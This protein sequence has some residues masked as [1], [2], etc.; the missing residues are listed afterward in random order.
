MLI[1]FFIPIIHIII[2]IKINIMA[3]LICISLYVREMFCFKQNSSHRRC[4]CF[5]RRRG[6]GF[7]AHDNETI[8]TQLLTGSPLSYPPPTHRLRACHRPSRERTDQWQHGKG[9]WTVLSVPE[10]QRTVYSLHINTT[11]FST[12]KTTKKN[13]FVTKIQYI[14]DNSIT[15]VW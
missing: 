3:I 11:L 4:C 15:E 12:L 2:L 14:V 5:F 9:T 13:I 7:S 6:G 8:N 10:V 1:Y